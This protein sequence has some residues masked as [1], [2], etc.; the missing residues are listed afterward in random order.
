MKRARLLSRETPLLVS[1]AEGEDAP[2][3]DI[4]MMEDPLEDLTR[5]DIA[6]ICDRALGHLTA[7]ART[8]VAL[9]YLRELP[10]REI[11]ERTGLSEPAVEAQ[12]FRARRSLRTVLSTD[13]RDMAEDYGLHFADPV[14][15]GWRQTRE[16]CFICGQQRLLGM[17]EVM[18][19]GKTSLRLKC[20]TC[21]PDSTVMETGG[22]VS[23]PSSHS[24][25]PALKRATKAVADFYAQMLLPHG[26]HRC[27]FCGKPQVT[28][29]SH[30]DIVPPHQQHQQMHRIVLTCSCGTY[31]TWSIVIFLKHPR[32]FDFF[33]SSARC[34]LLPE[35]QV[36]FNNQNAVQFTLM[37]LKSRTCLHIFA[38]P[39]TLT[40]FAIVAE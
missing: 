15:A 27:V 17:F 40:L 37:D 18:A 31:V 23:L 29:V 26:D 30:V 34:V 21:S 10:Q 32:V 16:Y 39:I 3:S 35:Q 28:T 33:F 4:P 5:Q 8:L 11:A 24:F 2:V 22:I 13:L 9:R 38:D 14:F 20:P 6:H 36:T 1:D 25:R 12:L 19:N 7:P